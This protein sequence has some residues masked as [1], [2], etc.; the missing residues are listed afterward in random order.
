MKK[1]RRI[2][3]LTSGGDAPGM[4]A[5][6]RAVTRTAIANGV[7]VI[8]IRKGYSG[9]IKGDLRPLGLRDVSN[10][11]NRG[12]TFLYS[13]RCP[14]FQAEEGMAKAIETC[15][16]NQIDGIVAIGGDGTF[17]GATDLTNR[18]IPCV[19]IP[20]TI[21]NDVSST[22][23]TIGYD[24]A[25]NTVIDIIDKLRDT[26]ESHARCNVVEVLGRGAGDIALN[27]AIAS[28]ATASVIPEFPH[29]D[30]AICEGIK[31]ARALGKRNFIV[32][33][34]EGLGSDYAPELAEKIENTTGVE[35][36]FARLAHIV[37]GGNPTLK[38]RVLASEM[39]VFA[40]NQ[41]LEGNS[42]IVICE[43]NGKIVSCDINYALML[44]R[45]YKGKLKDGDL[46]AFDEETIA[47]MRAEVEEKREFMAWRKNVDELVNL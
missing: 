45:M 37:R 18:G 22:D 35:T 34:S 17:R 10:I 41:L 33:V 2:G 27:T 6:I 32:V 40:V 28:G 42:N 36:K 25:M 13:D 4:N 39:G 47:K 7:E 5:A 8:G 15:R 29:D 14:E 38:D 26:C 1:F 23:N 30:E 12:G 21:D 31:E 20:G 24:T 11:I 3:V 19:G 44:D 43:R 16:E 9:L 46:D